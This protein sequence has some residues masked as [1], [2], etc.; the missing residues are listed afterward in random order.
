[1]VNASVRM[2][3][4]DEAW[5]LCGVDD[6]W[7][8]DPD[9]AAALTGVPETSFK[10]LLCHEPDFADS[11]ARKSISLQLSGHSHGGQVRLPLVGAPILPYLGRKYPI[12]L[13]AVEGS[14]LR[15][16]TNVGLGV[17]FP[18]VRFNCW[19]EVTHLTLTRT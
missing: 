14:N 5:W 4:G 1:M 16:Y 2:E 12:G 19:P 17:I 9:L 7:S 6:V 10:I 18:P 8:G 15:V 11:A 13:Q 3:T